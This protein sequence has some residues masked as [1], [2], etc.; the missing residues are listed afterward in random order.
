M[1]LSDVIRKIKTAKKNESNS[2][3][4]W[5][6]FWLGYAD[7]Q[8]DFSDT[9]IEYRVSK[10]ITS[11]LMEKRRFFHLKMAEERITKAD[12]RVVA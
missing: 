6:G 11:M 12:E 4:M 5:F 2:D 8:T 3:K 7:A 9:L 1:A 10:L